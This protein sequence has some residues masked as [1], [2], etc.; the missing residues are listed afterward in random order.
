MLQW[1]SS[2]LAA[3][4]QKLQGDETAQRLFLENEYDLA[5]A[6]L[7]TYLNNVLLNV[8]EYNES[9]IR[10]LTANATDLYNKAKEGGANVGDGLIAGM[11]EK[12]PGVTTSI[13]NVSNA[14][15]NGLKNKMDMRSPS[16]V[17]NGYG[18]NIVQGLAAGMEAEKRNAGDTATS[19][20]SWIT[21]AFRWVFGIHSP[22]A[23]MRDEV[24]KQM[25]L[26]WAAGIEDNKK[27]VS[28]AIDGVVPDTLS[29]VLSLDVTRNFYDVAR[30]AGSSTPPSQGSSEYRGVN[31]DYD[32]LGASVASALSG[33]GNVYLDG[34]KVGLITA[35][36][37]SS[38]LANNVVTLQRSGA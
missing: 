33:Q 15:V 11:D 4:Y 13:T 35:K 6:A 5:D 17:M 30:S 20:G 25:M 16:K 2:G 23:V 31:I 14:I 1:Y 19:V 24:G 26:G 21:N 36:Y 7:Q 9:T 29:S 3:E 27:L 10:S 28:S 18:R 37:V 32:R 8:E 22:S 12:Q 34:K 38:V